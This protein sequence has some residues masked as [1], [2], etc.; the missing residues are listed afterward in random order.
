MSR[1]FAALAANRLLHAFSFGLFLGGIVWALALSPQGGG[2]F[3]CAMGIVVVLAGSASFICY[4][5]DRVAGDR[6]VHA[7][8]WIVTIGVGILLGIHGL[9]SL[10]Q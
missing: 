3:R 5:L 7:Q 9:G 8:D 2:A 6:L 1:T 4:A 10:G